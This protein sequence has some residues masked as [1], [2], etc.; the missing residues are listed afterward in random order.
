MKGGKRGK[1]LEI[2]LSNVKRMRQ[3]EESIYRGTQLDRCSQC[4]HETLWGS[5]RL[6]LCLPSDSVSEEA[7][8]LHG[9]HSP[10]KGGEIASQWAIEARK[11]KRK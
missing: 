6:S 8:T 2:S 7:E 9:A 5:L 3:G 10:R 11:K 1:A 4:P